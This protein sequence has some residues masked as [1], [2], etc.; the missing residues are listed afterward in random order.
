MGCTLFAIHFQRG[1]REHQRNENES[2][3]N[4][5]LYY[6][7]KTT[8]SFKQWRVPC[9]HGN[10][11]TLFRFC[12]KFYVLF[13]LVQN[14]SLL[15]FYFRFVSSKM[16]GPVPK[17]DIALFSFE[18]P[19][20]QLRHDLDSNVVP[21]GKV[22]TGIYYHRA[23]LFKVRWG[24]RHFFTYSVKWLFSMKIPAIFSIWYRRRML[25]LKCIP[26]FFVAR[27]AIR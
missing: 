7:I 16:G 15:T 21:I 19:I 22:Q 23:L 24:G 2:K 11:I 3:R 12:H 18:L 10:F 1:K 26:G 4:A 27:K 17:D 8:P 5:S 14:D 25:S 9:C 20:S 6:Y 13:P